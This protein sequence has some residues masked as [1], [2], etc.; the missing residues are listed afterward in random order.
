MG[1]IQSFN[2]Y[3]TKYLLSTQQ[4]NAF[5]VAAADIIIPDQYGQHTICNLYLDTDDYYFIEH[6][7]DKP[8][9][10]EKLRLRS[11]GNA[12]NGGSIVF[13][14]IKKKYGG[15][16]YKRRISI[17]LS[18]AEEYIY[19]GTMP[20]SLHSFSDMQIYNEIDFLM[21]KY[22]PMPKVYLAYDR[23]ACFSEKYPE[24]RVTFDRN[25]RSRTENITLCSDNN[26]NPLDVGIDGY[27]LMELKTG[28]AVPLEIT[29]ILS[30][31]KLY[32]TSFS[33]YGRV[34]TDMR[35]ETGRFAAVN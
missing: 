34:Y 14:E 25:I 13:L 32:P 16:V 20:K 9:Y 4:Y 31:L 3:E 23:I 33:K 5:R 24:L 1:I 7:L 18:A 35:A 22:A 6:S 29:K 12:V 19:S 21:K 11:Y 28:Y 15:I 2:R 8:A 30:R 10:K 17:P 27:Y 26:T